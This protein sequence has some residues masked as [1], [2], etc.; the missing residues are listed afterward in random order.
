MV[1]LFKGKIK[2]KKHL[3][4]CKHCKTIFIYKDSEKVRKNKVICPICKKDNVLTENYWQII[5][6][7]YNNYRKR[8]ERK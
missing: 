8:E 3:R 2:D 1:V 7:L 6:M 5:K 4:I